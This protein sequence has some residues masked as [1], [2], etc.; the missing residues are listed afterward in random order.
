MIIPTCK[1]INLKL[2]ANAMKNTLD[3]YISRIHVFT[4]KDVR[5]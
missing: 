1:N 3:T 4:L 5:K 2:L